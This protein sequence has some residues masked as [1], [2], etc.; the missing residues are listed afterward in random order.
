M[1]AAYLGDI[2]RICDIMIMR[3]ILASFLGAIAL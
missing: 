1:K 2:W 3:S